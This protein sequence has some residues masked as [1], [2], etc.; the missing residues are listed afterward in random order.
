MS[1][2]TAD[3]PKDGIWSLTT[4]RTVTAGV[5]SAIT[6]IMGF[7][8]FLGFIPLPFGNATIE[9]VPVILGAVL[10]G[11]VVGMVT[12]VVFGAISWYRALTVP[13]TPGQIVFVLALR[14]PL[15]AVLPRILI[16][17]FSWL[18]F[19]GLQRFNRDA[20]AFVAGFLGSATNT[21]FVVLLAIG[22]GYWPVSFAAILLPQ[23]VLEAA[24]AAIITTIVARA[25]YIVRARLI[26]AP[27]TKPRDQLPY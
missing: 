10:E 19:A 18:V 7:I 21:I 6:L 27:E 26:R 11:P 14:N 15:V 16:G 2:N 12:G 22:L 20:A 9:H 4:R 17:L 13:P 8:P 5:L 1:E 25:V 23:A 24:V 3:A